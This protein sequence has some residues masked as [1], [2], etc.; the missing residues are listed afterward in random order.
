M[1]GSIKQR[2]E[3]VKLATLENLNT[4]HDRAL[5]SLYDEHYDGIYAFCVHR[6][7]CRTA[8]ED[9]TSQIFLAA[10]KGIRSF[11]SDGPQAPARW[12]YAIAANHC[13]AYLRK[14]LRRRQIFER[15]RQEYNPHQEKADLPPDWTE[16]YAAIAQLKQVEQTVITLRFFENME[17]EQIAAIINKRQ[18]AVRVILHRGLK[19]LEKMLSSAESG[20]GN[21]GVGH[22]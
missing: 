19:K 22:E 2:R 21:R 3:T 10:A 8:A 11:S 4:M 9:V 5:E 15:F 17:Y 7:F 20:F 1:V 13:N 16:V 6:L 12:L 18:P 14:N